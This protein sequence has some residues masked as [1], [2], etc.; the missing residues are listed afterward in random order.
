MSEIVGVTFP[1]PKEYMSRFFDDGKTVFIKPATVFKDLRA[2]MKLVFYQSHEDTGYVG[3]ATIK[4]IVIAD[5]PLAFFATYGDAVFLTRDEVTAY[6]SEQEKWQGLRVRK[7]E[8]K[9]RPWLAL[10]LEDI[11]RYERPEKP[12]RFVPVGGKYLR[13]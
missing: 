12:E 6:Q 9:K 3:E 8:A 4:R 2:G 7:G 11:R 10:E 5:D 13:N 1:V